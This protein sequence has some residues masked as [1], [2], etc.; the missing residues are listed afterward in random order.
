MINTLFQRFIRANER[1]TLAYK[2]LQGLKY[3]FG[4][5]SNIRN[6]IGIR[7][8]VEAQLRRL[9]DAPKKMQFGAGSGYLN[10]AAATSIEGY[11]DSDI[12]GLLPIDVTRPVPIADDR[13]D[14]VFSSHLIEHLH[15]IEID[16]FVAECARIL[17]PGGR[18][19][20]ATPSLQ[21]VAKLIYSDEQ[22]K[23]QEMYAVHGLAMFGRK[24]TPARVINCLCHIN[25]GH[26]FMLDLETYT[27]ICLGKGFSG[28]ELAEPE[29]LG[30]DGLALFFEGKQPQYWLE[31]EIWV[32]TR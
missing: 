24:P 29:E 6:H 13:L 25:Y 14:T 12:F 18:M 22:D 16:S 32:A 26:K 5:L 30:D 28:V 8:K 10:E 27:D 3:R 15:Q 2:N 17:K 1:E 9:G 21:K 19:I 20:T 4:K 7:A 23:I 31:T 11:V